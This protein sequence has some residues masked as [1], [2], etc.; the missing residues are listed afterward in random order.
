LRISQHTANRLSDW[1]LNGREPDCRR[2]GTPF[3]IAKVSTQS[4][5]LAE[6]AMQ[7]C[8]FLVH[9]CS[10]AFDSVGL[11]SSAASLKY[12]WPAGGRIHLR[13]V[14]SDPYLLQEFFPNRMFVPCAFRCRKRSPRNTR[15][16]RPG[17]LTA[18]FVAITHDKRSLVQSLILSA[19]KRDCRIARLC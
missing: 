11:R 14:T 4:I 7:R 17:F 15:P 19:E 2:A 6:A 8:A 9:V 3:L 10:P 18:N 1:A 5:Q 12:V 16:V 13:R